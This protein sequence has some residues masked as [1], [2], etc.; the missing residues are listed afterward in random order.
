MANKHMRRPASHGLEPNS[1]T[2]TTPRA[3]EDVREQLP[4]LV[5][6]HDGAATLEGSLVISYQTKH[7]LNYFDCILHSIS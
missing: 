5:G 4:L 1:S 2:L 3:A 6:A 7:P